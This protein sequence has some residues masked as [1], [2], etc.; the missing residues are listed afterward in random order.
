[1]EACVCECVFVTSWIHFPPACHTRVSCFGGGGAV[2]RHDGPSKTLGRDETR[3]TNGRGRTSRAGGL[4]WEGMKSRWFVSLK[5]NI[6]SFHL[7]RSKGAFSASDRK[8]H[9]DFCFSIFSF[10]LIW[11]FL[12]I[13]LLYISCFV[14]LPWQSFVVSDCFVL[15]SLCPGVGHP[16]LVPFSPLS[17]IILP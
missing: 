9:L 4:T 11:F 7:T 1:M 10:I 16:V 12:N 14:S 3:Q 8:C 15:H 6:R 17:H 2:R 13:I 5:G